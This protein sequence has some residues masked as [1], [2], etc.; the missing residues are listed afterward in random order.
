MS[1]AMLCCSNIEA[2]RKGDLA[3]WPTLDTLYLNNNQITD[4]QL[5]TFD[6]ALN[7]DGIDL[8]DNFI[9]SLPDM[10]FQH[11]RKLRV[12]QISG[13]K[14]TR[15]SSTALLGLISLSFI[16]FARNNIA[17]IAPG[18]FDANRALD[19]ISLDGN[20]P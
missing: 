10:L 7:L 16:S 14:I 1:L 18:T 12:I 9:T 20:V 15:V 11:L 2:L 19:E 3:N 4:I 17:A 6:T 13:N 8:Q 5:G